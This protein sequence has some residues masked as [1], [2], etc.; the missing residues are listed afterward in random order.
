MTDLQS[1]S[2]AM[3]LKNLELSTTGVVAVALHHI[4]LGLASLQKVVVQNGDYLLI[5]LRNAPNGIPEPWRVSRIPI[6]ERQQTTLK[7]RYL[8]SLDF[9]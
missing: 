5:P 1:Q 7:H 8:E 6:G 4:L 3:R 9:T 2:Q